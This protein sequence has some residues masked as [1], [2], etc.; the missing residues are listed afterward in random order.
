MIMCGP[1]FIVRVVCSKAC[2]CRLRAT[3]ACTPASLSSSWARAG[4]PGTSGHESPAEAA[5][6]RARAV[7]HLLGE[8]REAE[9]R[10]EGGGGLGW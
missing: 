10:E 5:Q 1:V 8:P 3:C 2:T 7:A 9:A 6:R 4:T